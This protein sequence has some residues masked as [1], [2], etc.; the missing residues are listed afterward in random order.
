MTDGVECIH[1]RQL[2]AHDAGHGQS[3]IHRPQQLGCLSDARRE[4]AVLHGP[5]HFRAIDLHAADAEHGQDG[6]G[7]HDDAHASQPAQQMAP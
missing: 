4:L 3:G 6:D 2:Q 5:R 7:Q 1:P